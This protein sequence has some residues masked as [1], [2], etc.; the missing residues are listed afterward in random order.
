MQAGLAGFS[1]EDYSGDDEDPIYRVDEAAERSGRRP[2]RPIPGRRM[3]VT[4]RC[5][6]HLHGRDDL[7]DT[8][9]RLQAYQE[10]GADV[11]YAP[12]PTDSAQ[13]RSIVESVDRR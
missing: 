6:N 8:I 3:V 11:L 1:I 9:A 4:G 13:I 5:E 10:A 7:A 12:G 2:R